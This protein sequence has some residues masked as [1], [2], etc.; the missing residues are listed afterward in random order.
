MTLDVRRGSVGSVSSDPLHG[1]SEKL[2]TRRNRSLVVISHQVKG[3][4][5]SL[6]CKIGLYM[7]I[8]LSQ[9]IQN[10]ALFHAKGKRNTKE[11]LINNGSGYN[12]FSLEKNF[13][14]IPLKSR[15]CLTLV[16]TRHNGFLTCKFLVTMAFSCQSFV[17]SQ[18]QDE[19]L[20]S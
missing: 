4:E 20:C 1:I 19:I 8:S 13:M 14:N 16:M 10:K 6:L 12:R 7:Q 5:H 18:N 9:C 17:K 3:Q 2:V 11:Y 15:I